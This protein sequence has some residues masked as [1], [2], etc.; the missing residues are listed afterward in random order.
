MPPSPAR[1]ANLRRLCEP[2]WASPHQD[3]AEATGAAQVLYSRSR[4]NVHSEAAFRAHISALFF[5][6][7]VHRAETASGAKKAL[8]HFRT[9]KS[10]EALEG[11]EHCS[12]PPS[13]RYFGGVPQLPL[14][15]ASLHRSAAACLA[16]PQTAAPIPEHHHHRS[17]M[18][19]LRIY[20]EP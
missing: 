2:A 10:W 20:L 8:K 9:T 15:P 14:P 19:E 5:A 11:Q 13:R 7:R 16:A 6:N 12:A 17:F 3:E 1:A 18:I 4:R